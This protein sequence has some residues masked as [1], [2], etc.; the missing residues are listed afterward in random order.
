MLISICKVML[1]FCSGGSAPFLFLLDMECQEILA[2][3]VISRG[4]LMPLYAALNGLIVIDADYITH[5]SQ[6]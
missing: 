5:F 2:T 3:I 6:F 1:I 4:L